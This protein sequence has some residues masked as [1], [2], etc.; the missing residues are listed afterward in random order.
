[1]VLGMN[2]RRDAIIRS[3]KGE[4]KEEAWLGMPTGCPGV[5]EGADLPQ[6]G[7]EEGGVTPSRAARFRASP[8]KSRGEKFSPAAMLAVRR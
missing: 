8:E 2:D 3:G 4:V 7:D 6:A 5:A 1:M